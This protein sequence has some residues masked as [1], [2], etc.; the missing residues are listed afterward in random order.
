LLL[1][2]L[3]HLYNPKRGRFVIFGKEEALSKE[4]ALSKEEALW[5]IINNALRG[6]SKLCAW[7]VQ[8]QSGLFALA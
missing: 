5:P 8:A 2:K 4:G 6:A 1:R 3:E 7:L